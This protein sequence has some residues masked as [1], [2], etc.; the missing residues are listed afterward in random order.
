[1]KLIFLMVSIAIVYRK[2]A[3]EEFRSHALP[4]EY[5]CTGL[6]KESWLRIDTGVEGTLMRASLIK[7]SLLRNPHTS[8]SH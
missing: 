7:L 5:S 6:R 8:P 3:V 4:P 2:N 1:M